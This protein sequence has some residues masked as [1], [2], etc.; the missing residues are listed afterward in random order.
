MGEYATRRADGARIKIGTC[1]DM[2]YLR[3]SDV[4]AVSA[5]R[6]NVDPQTDTG[7]RFRVPF[8]DEDGLEPGAYGDPFRGEPLLDGPHAGYW[9]PDWLA[10]A[11]PG[12]LQMTHPSGLLVNVPCHHGFKL[13]DLGAAAS[14]HWNGQGVPLQLS[15]LKRTEAGVLPVVGCRACSRR[16]VRPWA[17]VLPRLVD[18]ALRARLEVYAPP[19]AVTAGRAAADA[20]HHHRAQ[21]YGFGASL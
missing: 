5:L 9:V 1:S 21:A 20:R 14:V 15:N 4:G 6:G 2:L 19:E 11:E 16:W 10:D 17:D 8:P 7:L 13:P 12:L 3:L 18:D